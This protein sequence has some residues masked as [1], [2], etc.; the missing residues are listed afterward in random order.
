MTTTLMPEGRQKY[1]LSNG[2]TPA[3]GCLLY[4]FAAGTSTPKAAYTDSAGLVPHTNPITLDANGEAV[5]YWSGAYKVDLKTALGAQITGYPVD[6]FNTDTSGIDTLEARLLATAGAGLVGFS[7]LLAYPVSTVGRWLVDLA[8]SAG[9]TFIGF[10]QAGAGA[11]LRSLQ[12][13][14][15]DFVN[16]KDFGAVCDDATDDRAAIQAALNSGAMLVRMSAG[17]KCRI[18]GT[19]A[20]STVGQSLVGENE[21]TTWITCTVN[22][23]PAIT[24]ETGMTGNSI[25]GITV[26][27]VGGAIA[28][29]DG[30]K[31]LGTGE[32]VR[33]ENLILEKHATGLIISTTDIGYVENVLSQKNELDGIYQ[34]NVS[35]YGP[36]QW[37][38]RNVLCGQNGRDGI[39]VESVNGPG[40]LIVGTWTGV[41]TFANSGFG[42]NFIGTA[43]TPIFDIRINQAFVGSDN[44]GGV[45]LDT[46]GG[47]HRIN[48]LF[49]ERA[50]LDSTGPTLSTPGSNNSDGLNITL[51]NTDLTI[52][53]GTINTNSR[54][55]INQFG[56]ILLVS[57]IQITANGVASIVGQMNGVLTN[58]GTLVMSGCFCGNYSGVVQKYGIAS[59]HDKMTISGNDFSGNATGPAIFSGGVATSAIIGN[60]PSTLVSVHPGSLNGFTAGGLLVG[61]ATGGNPGIGLTNVSAGMLKNNVAYN[62][63]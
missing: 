37:K 36:S 30:I 22:N 61:N 24:I 29:G 40:G 9:S 12:S 53:D 35:T 55:G 32:H 58:A 15:R 17:S 20:M 10:I 4:T 47:N 16:V 63:P 18:S 59:N 13:K 19:L 8:T 60:R 25:K 1:W 43:T 34:T 21:N 7:N 51:N 26:S 31:M 49:I 27:R 62:N 57:N 52:G 6:N 46:Y 33:F 2:V 54:N 45:R 41:E 50:G 11:V 5:I 42:F 44:V 39:R 3:A 23:V 48:G 14:S 56:G 28:G 38:F